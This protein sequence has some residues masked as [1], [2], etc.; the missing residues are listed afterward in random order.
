MLRKFLFILMLLPVLGLADIPLGEKLVQRLWRDMK[1]RKVEKIKEY[2]SEEFQALGLGVSNL[3]IGG[4][5]GGGL[6]RFQELDLIENSNIISYKLS[7]LTS[8][9]GVN[10]IVVTY[11]ADVVEMSHQLLPVESTAPRVTV[12]KKFEDGWKWIAQA[13]LL[14]PGSNLSLPT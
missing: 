9:Q 6:N 10:L 5:L 11:I 7:N 2:T 3:A 14:A 12:W 4:G 1:A 13:D 8:T